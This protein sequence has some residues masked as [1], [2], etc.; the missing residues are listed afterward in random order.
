MFDGLL[1]LGESQ[2]ARLVWF[3]SP[4]LSSAVVQWGPIAKRDIEGL[5]PRAGKERRTG[6][7]LFR[8]SEDPA[9][10]QRP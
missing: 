8:T 7:G 6:W 4:G 9:P 1:A 5:G 2:T 3:H 10:A